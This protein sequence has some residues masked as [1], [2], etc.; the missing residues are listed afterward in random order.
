M[1]YYIVIPAHNEADHIA[2]TLTSLTSQTLLPERIVVVNDNS[3]DSTAQIVSTYNKRYPWIEMIHTLSSEEHLPGS[4]V[5]NAFYRGFEH[6]DADYD[7]I[8]KFDADLI[9]PKNYLKTI[10]KHFS[11]NPKTGMVG[12]HCLIQKKNL[13][14]KKSLIEND[15]AWGLEQL[16]DPDHIRGALKAYRKACFLEI[17]KLKPAMGWD[18]VDELLAQYHGWQVRT[19]EG[20]GV[21]HLKPTGNRYH[22]KAQFKQGAAFY[23]MRYGIILTCIAGLKLSFRKKKPK[24]FIDYLVGYLKAAKSQSSYLVTK[25][26]GIFIRKHRWKKIRDKILG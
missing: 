10:D 20:L 13:I 3:T 7:V 16:S 6:L 24:L 23:G 4:K 18:T 1:R 19:V 14:K 8:C 17:G 5:I 11:A 2:Q 9:F 25:D 12:G 22:Q 26:Q 15:E 21:R